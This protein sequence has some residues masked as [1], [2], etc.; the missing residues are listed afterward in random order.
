MDGFSHVTDFSDKFAFDVLKI[1]LRYSLTNLCLV[2]VIIIK[3]LNYIGL[4]CKYDALV[5]TNILLLCH[6][7]WQSLVI[8]FL[9]IFDILALLSEKNVSL[10]AVRNFYCANPLKAVNFKFR[11]RLYSDAF[12]LFLQSREEE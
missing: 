3:M 4:S 11:P 1:Y 7:Q 2:I 12:V 9:A 8:Q 10:R 5:Y 6:F